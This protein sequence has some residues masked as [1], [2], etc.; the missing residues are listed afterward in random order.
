MTYRGQELR[1]SPKELEVLTL[2][3]QHPGRVYGQ[4]ELIQTLWPQSTLA[5]D[6]HVVDGYLSSLRAKLRE[7]G[8]SGL[9]RS[10]GGSGYVLRRPAAAADIGA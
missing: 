10:A 2:L 8:A 6:R 3:M 4:Q 9:L 7:I 1:L 5:L